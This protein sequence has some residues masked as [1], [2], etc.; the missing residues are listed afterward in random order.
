MEYFTIYKF[1]DVVKHER[2]R[3]DIEAN[4][5][6]EAIEKFNKAL[7]DW[8]IDQYQADRLTIGS[9]INNQRFEDQDGNKIERVY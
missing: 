2:T 5:F 6:D 8:S 7:E 9:Y 3:Y 1:Q 4:S